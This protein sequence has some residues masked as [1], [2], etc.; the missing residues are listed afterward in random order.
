MA[1]ANG[2][3]KGRCSGGEESGQTVICPKMGKGKSSRE[4]EKQRFMTLAHAN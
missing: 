1:T 3:A 4:N 2:E